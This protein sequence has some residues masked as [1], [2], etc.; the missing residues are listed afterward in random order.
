MCA[1]CFILF[2]SL[3][4]IL[5]SHVSTV[6]THVDL[7]SVMEYIIVKQE[8]GWMQISDYQ[9]NL[10]MGFTSFLLNHYYYNKV[11]G[12]TKIMALY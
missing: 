5:I 9:N 7:I 10:T 6:N 2:Y 4:I 8:D 3:I 1:L 11:N 12:S